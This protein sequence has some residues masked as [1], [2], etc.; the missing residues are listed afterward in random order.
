MSSPPWV[1]AIPI[2]R[3]RR[4]RIVFAAA[5][6]YNIAWGLFTIAYPQWLFDMTGMQRANHPQ[7]FA[8]LGMLIGLYGVLYLAV[9]AYPE[10]GW[11]CAAVGMAGKVLGPIGLAALLMS[12]AWPP[13]TIVLCLTNDIIWWVP[14]GQYLRDACPAGLLRRD[15]YRAPR[16]AV[17][18]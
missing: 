3:R 5:G 12:G 13:A 14:F 2:R 9:A 15:A 1:T 17:S 8:T 7:I 16:R 10:H 11:L 6:A 4:H 18:R